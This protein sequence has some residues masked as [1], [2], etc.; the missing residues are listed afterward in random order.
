M[1]RKNKFIALGVMSS[2]VFAVAFVVVPTLVEASTFTP[3]TGTTTLKVG[4]K[5]SNVV[6]LQQFISS[7]T[8]MYPSGTQDGKFGPN[9]RNGVIQFQLAYNL[10]ADG[11]V[12]PNTRNK[13]NS[14]IAAGQGIDVSAPSIYN[15]AVVP[16]GRNVSVS[17]SSN[18]AVK[19]T[20]FYDTN[21][22]NW[23]NWDDSVMSL[24]TPAI[25]GTQNTDSNFSSNKQFNLTNLSAGT[26]Y[27]YTIT[28]TDQSGN[29]S[30][31]APSV[32]TTGY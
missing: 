14:V 30:V 6:A 20:V 8:D 26:L 15:L 29:I 22:I 13:V 31:I 10:T 1:S 32:F 21:A 23:D 28:V 16:T 18:E 4:S 3:L 19:A 27:H 2:L 24:A 9:T 12:G 11:A 25:S 5:G 7:N 17:F